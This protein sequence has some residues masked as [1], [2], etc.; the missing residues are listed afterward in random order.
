[1][2]AQCIIYCSLPLYEIVGLKPAQYP[3]KVPKIYAPKDSIKED[4]LNGLCGEAYIPSPV[5]MH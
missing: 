3:M 2:L 4:V 5:T 1:M